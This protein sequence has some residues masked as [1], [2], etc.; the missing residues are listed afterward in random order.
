MIINGLHKGGRLTDK[1]RNL[2]RFT[3]QWVEFKDAE[4]LEFG[5]DDAEFVSG[6]LHL[7]DN[8]PLDRY[9]EM[10]NALEV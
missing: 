8:E 5:E 6:A 10:A 9:H 3:E 7:G 1:A 4:A 2:R